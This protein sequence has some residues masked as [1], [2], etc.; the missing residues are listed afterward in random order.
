MRI[1]EFS[2]LFHEAEE[3][4]ICS[5]FRLFMAFSCR[6]LLNPI[7][8]HLESIN[9]CV[10]LEKSVGDAVTLSTVLHRIPLICQRTIH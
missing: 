4:I 8:L 9:A 2:I 1:I 6:F 5:D 7:I 3:L 10:F